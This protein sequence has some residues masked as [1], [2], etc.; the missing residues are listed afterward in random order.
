MCDYSKISDEELKKRCFIEVDEEYIINSIKISEQ[1][2]REGR[3]RVIV[4]ASGVD[5]KSRSEML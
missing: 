5:E 4:S 1:Q 3:Y 2:L